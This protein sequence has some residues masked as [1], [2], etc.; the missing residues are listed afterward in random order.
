[1]SAYWIQGVLIGFYVVLAVM[2]GYNRKT[3]PLSAYYIGCFIKDAG[4]MALAI[5]ATKRG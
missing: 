1:M 2:F 3:W 4:V 5:L